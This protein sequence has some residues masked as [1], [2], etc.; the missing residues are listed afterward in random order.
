MNVHKSHLLTQVRTCVLVYIHMYLLCNELVQ[1]SCVDDIGVEG[2]CLQ[3]C[4]EVLHSRTEVSSDTQLLQSQHHVTSGDLPA[5]SPRKAV[6]KLGVCKF[7]QPPGCDNA[8]VPPNILAAAEVELLHCPT[9]W[10][11]SLKFFLSHTHTKS[12]YFKGMT[13]ESLMKIR[14]CSF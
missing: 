13:K 1:P 8:K 4:D 3:Q 2:I 11:K 12:M 14:R 5:L 9:A 7:M 10:T 6:A